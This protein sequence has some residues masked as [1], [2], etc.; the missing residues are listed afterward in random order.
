MWNVPEPCLCGADDCRQC[1]P[2][3][4][5]YSEPLEDEGPDLDPLDQHPLLEPE[6]V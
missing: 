4:F 2:E 6:P 3:N 5:D 1:H